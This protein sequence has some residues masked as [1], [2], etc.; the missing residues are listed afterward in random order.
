MRKSK[1]LILVLVMLISLT[2]RGQ[3]FG[4]KAGTNFSRLSSNIG[5]QFSLH[6]G[7]LAGPVVEV[8]ITEKLF[9][10]SGILYTQKGDRMSQDDAM[11]PSGE[12]ITIPARVTK[13]NYLEMPLNLAY[14]INLKPVKLFFQAGPYVAYALSGKLNNGGTVEDI[15]FGNDNGESNRF[16]VGLQ[17]GTG[18][19]INRF[20]L[21]LNFDAG[22]RNV[23]NDPYEGS[24]SKTQTGS[25]SLAYM[26]G[27]NR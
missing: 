12:V 27:E 5:E 16:D 24:T 19:E 23:K 1:M 3:N 8:G 26:F 11:L 2:G 20:I 22:F 21:G 25:F 9:V 18:V 10:N 15:N 17:L 7:F 13:I 4:I 14:K 6:T